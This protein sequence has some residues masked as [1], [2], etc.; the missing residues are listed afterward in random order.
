[1]G[2]GG[3][4]HG[5][6]N[7]ILVVTLWLN[8]TAPFPA[9]HPL[10]KDSWVSLLSPESEPLSITSGVNS[11]SRTTA[12]RRYVTTIIEYFSNLGF[13]GARFAHLGQSTGTSRNLLLWMAPSMW[14]QRQ[15]AFKG[16]G[17]QD[18]FAMSVNG[19]KFTCSW[20]EI[21][22]NQIWMKMELVPGDLSCSWRRVAQ[23]LLPDPVERSGQAKVQLQVF[24]VDPPQH[25]S[26][27]QITHLS[28][29][30]SPGPSCLDSAQN[31][32]SG[33]S[34]RSEAR[35]SGSSGHLCLDPTQWGVETT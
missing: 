32:L 26:F 1:M 17:L 9:P 22:S 13:P 25:S 24:S 6:Q 11:A 10:H 34:K 12:T 21:H 31:F 29:K 5:T 2:L 4:I 23:F 3:L 35:L 30:P 16:P 33:I 19:S 8:S 18:L 20:G 28:M 7:Q 27:R 14:C 15:S